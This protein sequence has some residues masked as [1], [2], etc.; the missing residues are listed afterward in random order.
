MR[1]ALAFLLIL[2][3]PAIVFAGNGLKIIPLESD[4]YSAIDALYILEGKALPSTTRPW[5]ADETAVYLSRVSR[6]TAPELYDI[7]LNAVEEKPR[8][9]VD[10]VFGMTFGLK[11]SA[12]AYAHTNTDFSYRFNGMTNYLF[13]SKTETP[14]LQ[15]SWEAWAG[16]HFY[17]YVWY[18]YKLFFDGEKFSSFSFNFDL[19]NLTPEGFTSD[20]D[21]REPSRAFAVAGGK[22][23]SLE[24]GRDRLAMGTGASGSLIL[25][26]TFPYHNLLRFSLYGTRYKYSFIMSFFPHMSRDTEHGLGENSGLLF[27]MTHRFECTFLSER[28]YAAINESIMYKNDDG[29]ADVR[30]INPVMYFHNYFISNLANSIVDLELSYTLAKGWN[31]YFQFALD[32][33]ATPWEMADGDD[34]DPL[35]FGAMLGLRHVSSAGRGILTLNL[36]GAYTMPYLYLRATCI[37]EEQ[38]IQDPTDPGIGY[39]GMYRGKP[40]FVGYTYGNDVLAFDF[41]AAFE[42][43]SD[44]KVSAEFFFMVDGE[45]TIASLFD[46]DDDVFAPS[47]ETAFFWYAELYAKKQV[48]KRCAIYGQYDL[49]GNAGVP[50][51]QFVLRIEFKF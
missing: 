8:L 42:I 46:E 22:S 20:M 4:V 2:L 48:S 44:L 5:T 13:S 29:V 49:I 47:G 36:E 45:K 28:L 38:H 1:K 50:D 14:P 11:A 15:A 6:E 30:Y 21:Q 26:N 39:I 17:S 24:V 10:E 40:F 43:P 37:G 31:A 35:A 19:P 12:T 27:Y 23:W 32:Q 33:F 51:N 25:S 7:V 18:Q 34:N 16:E 41:K 3:I 9:E